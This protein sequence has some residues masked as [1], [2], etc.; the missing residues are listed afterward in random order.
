MEL[1]EIQ[2]DSS[3]RSKYLEVR[4]PD[5]FSYFPERFR[6]FTTRIMAIFGSTYLCEQLFSFM[7]STKTSQRTR[8][9]DKH[10][11]SLIKLGTTQKFQP[12][13]QEIVNKK[14]TSSLG[15]K[16]WKSLNSC[17]W[18]SV[19]NLCRMHF[20]CYW[21][22]IEDRQNFRYILL[23]NYMYTITWICPYVSKLKKKIANF[24]I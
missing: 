18:M 13:I 10:L 21:I 4:I 24:F 5:F 14:E 20:F 1:L 22:E 17:W 9:T 23:L 6:K 11:S 7:K 12:H 2:S 3:L 16:Q 19:L 15:A 8:L